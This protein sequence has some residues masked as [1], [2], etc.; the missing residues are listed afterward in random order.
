MDK[1]VTCDL[2]ENGYDSAKEIC[3]ACLKAF[4]L[5]NPKPPKERE[6]G[7]ELFVGHYDYIKGK[8][9]YTKKI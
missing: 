1:C 2:S 4:K 9:I 7:G 5:E 8:Y 6:I 3:T